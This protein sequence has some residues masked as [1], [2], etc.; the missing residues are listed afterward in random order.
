[1]QMLGPFFAVDHHEAG[2][3]P[4]E[5]WQPMAEL[6]DDPSVLEVRVEQLRGAL[7]AAGQRS[8]DEVSPRVAASV[9]HLAFVARLASPVIAAAAISGRLAS[10]QLDQLWWQPTLGGAF[11]LSMPPGQDAGCDSDQELAAAVV[12]EMLDGPIGALTAVI[13][14]RFAT[15]PL[16]LSGNVASALNGAIGVVR[17]AYPQSAERLAA[18]A[19][20]MHARAELRTEAG[21]FGPGFRRRSCCLIYQAAGRGARTLE[22]RVCGDCVLRTRLGDVRA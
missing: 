9:L 13:G 4:R 7:G 22:S 15:S 3:A 8:G 21:E 5:P 2:A 14:Y 20:Q 12:S 11:P 1:M 17:R 6:L 10:V 19:A 16:V 18:M